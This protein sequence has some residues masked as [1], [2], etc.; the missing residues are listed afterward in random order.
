MNLILSIL[1]CS[2]LTVN[3][4]DVHTFEQKKITHTNAMT[5]QDDL[6]NSNEVSLLSYSTDQYEPNDNISEA[7][8]ICSPNFYSQNS[9]T[10]NLNAT[11]DYTSLFQDV[12]YY[13]FTIFTDSNVKI[14]IEADT[15]YSGY[16]QFSLMNYNYY[17]VSNGY[18]YHWPE[19]VVS[20]YDGVR[21]ISFTETL[22]PGT[23]L[24]YLRGMQNSEVLNDLPYS[25]NVIVSKETQSPNILVSYLKN[26]SEVMGAVWLSDFIPTNNFSIFNLNSK[27][28]YYKASQQNLN[29]PDYALDKLRYISNGNA[30]KLANYYIWDPLLK[31]V[32]HEIFI[33]IRDKFNAML[34]E[35]EKIAGE[36]SLQYNVVNGVLSVLFDIVG[37]APFSVPV[38]LCLDV[39]NIV[40]F[41]A[42]D[43]YFNSIMPEFNVNQSQYLAF[44][45]AIAAYTDLG[46]T[47]EEKQN[48][49]AIYAKD[50]D[51]KIIQ[52][53]IFYRLGINE[54]VS[55]NYDEHYYSLNATNSEFFNYSSLIYN[56]FYFYS[57]F[58]NDYYCRGKIYKIK[59][60]DDLT[61]FENLELAQP[62]THNYDGHYC[63]VC[64]LYTKAHDYDN[65]YIYLNGNTHRAF[66]VCGENI[67]QGHAVVSGSSICVNCKGKADMGFVQITA[68]TNIVTSKGSFVLPNGVIVLVKEDVKAYLDGSLEFYDKSLE[69]M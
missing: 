32:L 56:D 15:A 2:G 57:S 12:D 34:E 58:D 13:Y 30:I 18:A 23:Y 19:D 6:M 67:I 41:S 53:P 4:I 3:S 61:N 66:C 52:I 69:T 5:T 31:H 46:L 28:V 65:S 35:N 38:M 59:N 9:Y 37:Y 64:D 48:V 22:K 68:T 50:E 27:Y 8:E 24:I 55:S 36:L 1:L 14:E 10:I 21:T 47:Y 60:F 33:V 63:T 20:N 45:T 25:L 49:E 29:Y 62:H 40:T 39:L 7:T 17:S 16:F 51:R 42:I 54:N 43:S 11:L 26:E 44:I